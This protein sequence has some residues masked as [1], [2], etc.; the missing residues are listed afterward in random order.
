M[1]ILG[2]CLISIKTEKSQH[3]QNYIK[4]VSPILKIQFFFICVT[5]AAKEYN[6]IVLNLLSLKR[7]C[8][9]SLLIIII[10]VFENFSKMNNK[11]TSKIV[12]NEYSKNVYLIKLFPQ[13][14]SPLE[15]FDTDS[16][17]KKS[18]TDS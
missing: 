10:P 18:S 14:G 4:V 7:C 12:E 8:S 11:D 6:I 15:R 5:F 2:E 3:T 13:A 1:P 17:H 16:S 9:V